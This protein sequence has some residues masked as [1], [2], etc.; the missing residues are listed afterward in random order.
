MDAKEAEDA[1]EANADRSSGGGGSCKVGRSLHKQDFPA[2][3]TPRDG[4]VQQLKLPRERA[5]KA[6]TPRRPRT[7]RTTRRPTWAAAGGGGSSCKGGRRPPL[8]RPLRCMIP[9]E[10][11]RGL[12]LGTMEAPPSTQRRSLQGREFPA[13]RTASDGRVQQLVLLGERPWTPRML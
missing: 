5:R 10:S 1:K 6:R 7:P 3:R 12:Q 13:G 2:G 4:G 8:T 9:A 11:S